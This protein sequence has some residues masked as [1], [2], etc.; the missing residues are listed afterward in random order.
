MSETEHPEPWIEL[1]RRT[2]EADVASVNE[3]LDELSPGDLALAISRLE[4]AERVALFTA[5]GPERSAEL[6]HA[7]PAPQ[8]AAA[9]S[10]LP[11]ATA[12]N[13]VDEL[14]SAEQADLLGELSAP[15]ADAILEELPAETADRARELLAYDPSTAGG[16]MKSEFLRFPVDSTL[17]EVLED[18]QQNGELYSDYAIQYGYV[19]TRDGELRGVLRLRDLLFAPKRARVEEAMIRDPLAVSPLATIDD[20]HDVLEQRRFV[21]LPVV[22]ES[23]LLLGVVEAHDV[24][25]AREDAA[26]DTLRKVS[27]IVGGE[28][29]RTMP[30]RVRSMRRLSWLSANIVLNVFAASVI[31]MYEDTLEAV[32]A[33]AVFLPI[34]S[35]MSGCSGNQAVLVSIRELSLGLVKPKELGRVLGKEVFVGMI[36]GLVLGVFLGGLAFFWKGNAYLGLVV[37]GALFVNTVLS[38]SLGGCL[39]LILKRLGRDPALASAPIL[40]TVTDLMGFLLVLSGASALLARL[41]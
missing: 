36:N 1:S 2:S 25:L 13:L 12:A 32:I 24:E 41:I 3:F 4:P 28:E 30:L 22:G 21:G 6:A 14:S 8:A 29:I 27:G 5:L 33:L 39:P 18:L 19:V 9:L 20:L 40:T 23:G 34:I 35:D 26:E 16:L 7:L 31:A 10:E 38:V 15:E 37:G 17:G 11:A